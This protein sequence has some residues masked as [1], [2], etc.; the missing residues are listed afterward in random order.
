M[1]DWQE[2]I[3]AA[4][5]EG[6]QLK[7]KIRQKKEDLNDADRTPPFIN[8]IDPF[9]YSPNNGEGYTSITAN[10]NESAPHPQGPFGKNLRH[11]LGYRSTAPRLCLTRRK[12]DHLG[13][14]HDQQ[15]PCYPPPIVVGHDLCLRA[16]WQLRRLRRPGQYLFNIQFKFP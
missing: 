9:S 3:I 1:S 12:T 13:R 10:C 11:A 6:E 8:D 5:R 4:K 15:T 7:E 14:L 2:K 16:L